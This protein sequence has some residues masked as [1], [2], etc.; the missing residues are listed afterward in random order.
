VKDIMFTGRFVDAAEAHAIGFVNRLVPADA[1]DA[2]TRALAT[3]IAS[4]APLTIWATKEM[5]RRIAVH[6]RLPHGADADIV[7]RCYTS[8]D[9]REGV[10]AFMEKRKPGW[11]GR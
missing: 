11:K 4:H 1:I 9:F 2:T 7:E 10:K 6:R 5:I 3:E 8:E